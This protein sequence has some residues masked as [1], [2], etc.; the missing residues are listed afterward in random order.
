MTYR[1]PAAAL[2]LA[3]TLASLTACQPTTGSTTTAPAGTSA[4]PVETSAAQAAT[5]TA[6]ADADAAQA[7]TCTAEFNDGQDHSGISRSGGTLTATVSVD[8]HGQQ[9]PGPL[10]VSIALFYR[11]DTS[12]GTTTYGSTGAVDDGSPANYSTYT[13]TATCKLGLWYIGTA[14][15]ADPARGPQIT[16]TTCS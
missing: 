7:A 10:S 12:I 9:V 4:A 14:V 11:P 2:A 8:C 6:A 1:A 15:G 5:T 3:L 13:T 16:V